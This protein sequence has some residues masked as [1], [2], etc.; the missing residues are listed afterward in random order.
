MINLEG[1]YFDIGDDIVMRFNLEIP[2]SE[3][4]HDW[5]EWRD[6]A[7]I[8]DLHYQSGE[9]QLI[10]EQRDDIFF[11][12]FYQ[13]RDGIID[14]LNYQPKIYAGIEIDSDDEF[15][16][17]NDFLDLILQVLRNV[18]ASANSDEDIFSE[19][20]FEITNKNPL[21]MIIEIWFLPI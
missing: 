15:L 19:N 14:E 3:G 11:D 16:E 5:S 7:I 1:N 17:A 8:F 4:P 12:E 13:V 21:R 2:R 20:V 6:Y 9:G 10:Q 18:G